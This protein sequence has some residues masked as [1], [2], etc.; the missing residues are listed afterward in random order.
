MHIEFLMKL[1]RN[2]ILDVTFS[3]FIFV[4]LQIGVFRLFRQWKQFSVWRKNVL[5]KKV[6][7][8]K[9]ALQENLFVLN[10]VCYSVYECQM[11]LSFYSN[12]LNYIV[13]EYT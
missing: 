13:F 6:D 1:I 8:C 5:N 3:S 9:K 10:N 7:K 12:N 4:Y 2:E 11:I